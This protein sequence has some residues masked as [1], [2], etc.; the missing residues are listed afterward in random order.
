VFYGSV[1]AEEGTDYASKTF[2]IKLPFTY[3]SVSALTDDNGES[4][5]SG[6]FTS[7]YNATVGDAGEFIVV[8][9]LAALP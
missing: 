2:I 3:D 4:T 9:E 7:K 1:L 6:N 5:I 8:N